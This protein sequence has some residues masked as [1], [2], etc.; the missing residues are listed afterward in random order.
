MQIIQEGSRGVFV[1]YLQLA[2]SRI[3]YSAAIDG[4][5]G[6]AT[7][8]AVLRLQR[9]YGLTADGIVGPATWEVLKPFLRGYA[10]YKVR[11][12]DT[13]F[14]IA[15]RFYT[16]ESAI[17]I[18]NPSLVPDSLQIGQRLT[19]PY[20]FSVV[21][22]SV[23]YSY[24]LVKLIYEGLL[25]R[26]PFLRGGSAGTSTLGQNL[27]YI[28]I[29][30]GT[31]QV[32]FN[33]AHHAN[34]WITTPLLLRFTEEYAKAYA[35]GGEIGTFP[36]DTL[37]TATSL[38]VLPMVNPDGVD[39]VTG[40]LPRDSA[41]Y[42][43]AVR[44]A[45]NYPQIPFPSGWKANIAG[46]DP[47]LNYPAGWE[48]AREIKFSQG[49]VSPAPRDYVGTAP[50]D[51]PE[52]R[53]VYDFTR[54]KDFL[55]TLSYHTQGKVIFWKY[56][57]LTP[58]GAQEIGEYFSRVSGYA[59]ADTPRVS[60]FAGYKDW[61]ILT[62]NRPGYTIEAGS[63]QNPLPISQFPEIYRDNLGILTGALGIFTDRP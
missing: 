48:E 20:G 52:P 50:L 42:Q 5:F 57:D 8:A 47:N 26:Y 38:F 36:A 62:Y 32:F 9:A 10:N 11:S 15:G 28:Q 4:V 21:P 34:E 30:N 7:R 14:K 17:R 61:Y 16:E 49:F 56:L 60:S 25:A 33:G 37:F 39:L 27:Y 3:G 53:A 13:L 2:L 58:P 31:S 59:L 24:F 44:Y 45:E 12:G 51:T 63:G 18:A 19:V 23:S 6:P 46:I 43:T 1:E 40:A 41:A 35:E 55:L 29:G 54:Q 22:T